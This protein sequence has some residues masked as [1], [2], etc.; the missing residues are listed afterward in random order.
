MVIRDMESGNSGS[1]SDQDDITS[2]DTSV[3]VIV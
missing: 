2:R 1:D 3:T